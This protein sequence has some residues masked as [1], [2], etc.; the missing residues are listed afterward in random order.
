MNGGIRYRYS[1]FSSLLLSCPSDAGWGLVRFDGYSS[2]VLTRLAVGRMFG[3]L[4]TALEDRVSGRSPLRLA[5]YSAHDTVLAPFL[6]GLGVFDWRWP[7]FTSHVEI[8]LFRKSSRYM[9]LS[10]GNGFGLKKRSSTE[11][12]GDGAAPR[13]DHYVRVRYNG[14]TMRLPACAAHDKHFPG[15]EGEVCTL[16]AFLGVAKK[17]SMTHEEWVRECSSE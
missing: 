6:C 10:W 17:F 8:E 7:P 13:E 2:P 5:V 3:D 11:V 14:Q 4:T 16:D 9:S 12:D 15:T 1:I